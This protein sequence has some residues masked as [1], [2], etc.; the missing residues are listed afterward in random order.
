ME[1][2]AGLNNKAAVTIFRSPERQK[3]DLECVE[4]ADIRFSTSRAGIDA[5][6]RI[7][8]ANKII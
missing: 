4:K 7:L 3:P 2:A 8:R 1:A 6:Q 5:I